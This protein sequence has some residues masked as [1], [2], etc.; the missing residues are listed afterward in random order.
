LE[1]PSTLTAATTSRPND[2]RHLPAQGVHYVA[3][4]V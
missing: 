4:Q 2:T 3:R 1:R